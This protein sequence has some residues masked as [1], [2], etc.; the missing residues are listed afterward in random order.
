MG[1]FSALKE[2]VSSVVDTTRS[3]IEGRNM[4]SESTPNRRVITN[5]AGD[6]EVVRADCKI[7]VTCANGKLIRQA[8]LDARKKHSE[9][10]FGAVTDEMKKLSDSNDKVTADVKNVTEF[11]NTMK[12][13]VEKVTDINK[14]FR[15]NLE[16]EVKV[17]DIQCKV[18]VKNEDKATKKDSP[19]V[20][21][22]GK[23]TAI[24]PAKKAIIISYSVGSKNKENIEVDL[25]N[26]CIGGDQAEDSG[27]N[28]DLDAKQTGGRSSQSRRTHRGGSQNNQDSDLSDVICE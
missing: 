9:T 28:C 3:K 16:S 12:Q 7:L 20:K 22:D 27:A 5:I 15:K 26:L 24:K 17:N 11:E 4:T 13:F 8:L 19:S 23:I 2:K 21:L 6:N 10:S 1:I 14:T 18:I 25:K